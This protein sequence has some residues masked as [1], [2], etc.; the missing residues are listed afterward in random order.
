MLA[1]NALMTSAIASATTI[2]WPLFCVG[3]SRV[4]SNSMVPILDYCSIIDTCRQGGNHEGVG[5]ALAGGRS[6]LGGLR[7]RRGHVRMAGVVGQRRHRRRGAPPGRSAD[8]LRSRGRLG[9][10]VD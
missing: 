8:V 9:T 1:S 3:R 5:L 2:E 7:R 4:S 6:G 10:A